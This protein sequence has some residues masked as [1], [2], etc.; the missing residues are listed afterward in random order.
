[1]RR[2]GIVCLMALGSLAAFHGCGP[3]TEIMK[4]PESPESAMTKESIYAAGHQAYLQQQFDS[5]A[6]LL[7]RA[8]SM[9]S[10]FLA[11]VKD[12]A[13]LYYEQGMRPGAGKDPSKSTALRA[14]R[15]FYARMEALGVKEADVY[16]RLCELSVTL[17]DDRSFLKHAK[18]YADLYPYDRQMYNLGIAYF[19][20]GEFQQVIKS[21]KDARDKFKDSP[22]LGGFYRQMGRAYR[23]IDRDQTAER[24]FNDG[25]RAVDARIAELKKVDPQYKAGDTYRRLADDKVS[26]L[27]ELKH[28]HQI[29]KADDKLEQ[30]ERQIKEMEHGK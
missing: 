4:P 2:V 28:L 22:Y 18:K 1:M 7:K 8:S 16:E 23:K 6:V 10:T 30:V 12:L 17:D 11:P 26:M 25:I 21:Q 24:T 13:Q 19:N 29:Y 27:T 14:A 9:D 5:A 3:T 20:A 15:S